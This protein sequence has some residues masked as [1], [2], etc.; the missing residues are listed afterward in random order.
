MNFVREYYD[1][2]KRSYMK[3]GNLLLDSYICKEINS[4]LNKIRY[5]YFSDIVNLYV[6]NEEIDEN[7]IKNVFNIKNDNNLNKLEF[8]LIKY[9]VKASQNYKSIKFNITDYIYYTLILEITINMYSNTF[10]GINRRIIN[11]ILKEN[12]FRFE[13]IDFKKKQSKFN[14][15]MRY[16]KYIAKNNKQY[17]RNLKNKNIEINITSLSNHRNYFII[18]IKNKLPKLI[19]YDQ[20][21][22]QSVEKNN[23]YLNKMFI[24]NFNLLIQQIIYLLEKDKFVIDKVLFSLDKYQYNRLA[25]NYLNNYN[26]MSNY[27]MFVSSDKSKLD[28]ISSKYERSLFIKDDE[29]LKNTNYNGLNMLVT[30]NFW[31]THKRNS[32]KYN[33]LN[34]VTINSNISYKFNKEEK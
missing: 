14:L 1:F 18:D 22:I 6:S 31:E 29:E 34:F 11:D 20:E 24:L 12:L 3:I 25:V 8:D 23:D 7:I 2:K 21:L 26:Y 27:I 9:V 19:K 30:N 33:G 28:I 4:K 10:T 17:F 32:K 16:L 15:L 5:E 13:F